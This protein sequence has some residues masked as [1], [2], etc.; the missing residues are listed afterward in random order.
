MDTGIFHPF[1]NPLNTEV[2]NFYRET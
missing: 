2:L 1:T